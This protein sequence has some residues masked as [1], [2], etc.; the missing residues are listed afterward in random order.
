[1]HWQID[2]PRASSGW[3]WSWL[4]NQVRSAVKI[5]SLGQTEGQQSIFEKTEVPLV[6]KPDRPRVSRVVAL[7]ESFTL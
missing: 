5:I 6:I 3:L 2:Y 7:A 4:E 1:M